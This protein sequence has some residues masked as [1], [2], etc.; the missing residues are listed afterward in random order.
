MAAVDPALVAASAASI[1]SSNDLLLI[2]AAMVQGSSQDMVP[3]LPK[4][5]LKRS[6]QCWENL[7]LEEKISL[8]QKVRRPI[9]FQSTLYELPEE[10][11]AKRIQCDDEDG[12]GGGR[13]RDAKEI[14][15]MM[16]IDKK[17][18]NFP[19]EHKQL[20]AMIPNID[21]IREALKSQRQPKPK[22]KKPSSSSSSSSL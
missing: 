18:V 3:L 11:L 6:R 13:P 15:S 19:V 22:R 21:D 12:G 4:V 20:K 1:P 7:T 10:F 8:K 5:Y 16:A 9:L 2:T 14:C 17:T